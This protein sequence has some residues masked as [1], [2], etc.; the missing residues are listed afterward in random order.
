MV[1][2][3]KEKIALIQYLYLNNETQ[4]FLCNDLFQEFMSIIPKNVCISKENLNKETRENNYSIV[5]LLITIF[6]KENP[7]YKKITTKLLSNY[8]E[9]KLVEHL[10]LGYVFF[11]ANI[12]R[13]KDINIFKDKK[14]ICYSEAPP[15]YHV[16]I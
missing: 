13:K 16:I 12:D 7:E 10:I 11:L 6:F 5:K 8:T 15:L 4:T 9:N 14:S 1:M 3:K 2:T